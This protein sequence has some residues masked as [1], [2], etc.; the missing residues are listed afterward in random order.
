[1]HRSWEEPAD[2]TVDP[3]ARAARERFDALAKPTGSLGRLEALGARLA[4]IAGSCPPPRPA[5]A[6]VAVF[7]ADHGV[8]AAGVTAWPQ[9]ITSTMVGVMASGRA[10][11]QAL[12]AAAQAEVVVVD[13]GVAHRTAPVDG[14]L[15]RSIRR[16]T[17]DLS[18]EPAMTLAEVSRALDVG[19]EVADELIAGGA[20]CLVTGEMGIGNTTPASALVAAYCGRSAAEVTGRGAGA[21]DETLARKVGAIES[22]LSRHDPGDDPLVVLA[23]LGGL[24]IAAMAGFVAAAASQRVPVVIDGVI[25]DAALL[26]AERL[27]PGVRHRVVA[28]HRSTEP[29]ATIAL[30]ELGLE[31]VLDLDMRLGEGTGAVLA[32]PLLDAAVRALTDVATIADVMGD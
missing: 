26:A 7:A 16:G 14:V 23:S 9:E 31:P 22:G 18:V 29:A 17:R 10:S 19:A 24:E 25:A 21:D 32:L 4:A 28:G 27:L 2:P 13:V 8:H 30:D 3:S 1:M 20:R 6:T 12:A 15:D 11:V 5:P